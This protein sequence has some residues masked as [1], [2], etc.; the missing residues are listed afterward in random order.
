M[1][2]VQ[3]ALYTGP[4]ST[5]AHRVAH[6]VTCAVLTLRAL[7][8]CPYSHAELVVDGVCHSSSVRDGGVRA[9]T[10]NLATGRW[11]VVDLPQADADAALARFAERKGLGYD[12][13]GALRW[14]LPFLRQ[15]PR[16]DYCFELVAHMLGLPEPSRWSALDLLDH[17]KFMETD[18]API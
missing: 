7:R 5:L 10:I 15:R 14:G 3:L 16:A 6:V 18:H 17:A 8:W 2:R 9:K 11:V 4:G 13:P 12:W 1:T